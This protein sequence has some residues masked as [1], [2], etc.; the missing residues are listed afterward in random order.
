MV[1]MVS[2]LY[3]LYFNLKIPGN[4]QAGYTKRLKRMNQNAKRSFLDTNKRRG[5]DIEELRNL[6]IE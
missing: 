5:K 2:P 6:R 4:L 1:L 3:P